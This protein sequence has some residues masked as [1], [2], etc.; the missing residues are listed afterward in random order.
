MSKIFIKILVFVVLLFLVNII[1]ILNFERR[2]PNFKFL[3][4]I[5]RNMID[6]DESIELLRE[7]LWEY[8]RCYRAGEPLISDLEFDRLLRRLEE[9]EKAAGE[10]VPLDSP[11]RRVGND[12]VSE[13]ATLPHR[14]PMLSI[15]NTYNLGELREFGNRVERQLKSETIDSN[16]I[17]AN[18]VD[19]N[20][21]DSNKVDSNK[22]ASSNRDVF[23]G[24]VDMSW[25][26]ELK[27]DGVAAALI[28]ED[29][30][31]VR[32]LTRGNGISGDDITHNIRTIKDIPLKLRTPAGEKPPKLLEVRGEI[33]MRNS[34]LTILNQTQ[35]ESG[36]AAYAN[37]RNVTAGSIR[38]L[39]SRICAGRRLRFFAHSIGE[40][41]GLDV[42]NH[43]DFLKA[44]EKF[45]INAT[46]NAK[47]FNSFEQ[48]AD[49]CE[50]LYNGD[51]NFL[52]TLDFEIDG[53]VLKA[54]DFSLR[55]RLGATSKYPRWVI[56]YKVEKYEA[57]TRLERISVQVGKTGVITPV[58]ELTPVEL[59][60]TTVARASLHNAEEIER[61][62]IRAGDIVV[63]EKAG[64]IIPHVVRVEKHLR[65]FE[66]GEFKFPKNC[67]SCNS[68]LVKDDG[69][70]YIRCANPECPA[71]IKERIRYFASRA[72]MDIEGLG[73]K[74]INQLVDNKL[75]SNFGDIYRLSEE[76][77]ET[78][79]IERMGKRLAEKLINNIEKSKNRDLARFLN[80][81]SIRHVG[82]GTAKLIAK[83]FGTLEKLR[84]AT[85]LEISE[86]DGVG[87]IIAASLYQFL[88]SDYGKKTIDDLIAEFSKN[89]DG[90]KQK[91]FFENE[92]SQN[93]LQSGKTNILT[94]SENLNVTKIQNQNQNLKT[95]TNEIMSNEKNKKPLAGLTI[96][97][98]GT[99]ENF[100]RD[101]I[102][103][104]VE[105][106]GGKATSSV[107][108]NTS[109]VLAG[110]KPG[111]T[112]LKQAENL[113]IKIIDETEFNKLIAEEKK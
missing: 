28:Y 38:L 105:F 112:K 82:V 14:I 73:D 52:S 64:K 37:T 33:Y 100:K 18:K 43:Y 107:S 21:V 86:I 102:N 15:E 74:L 49:Y 1:A 91:S 68:E 60:G 54:N 17:D 110:K 103:S 8:D 63:V 3:T 93:L 25:V 104:I 97:V 46:P 35:K 87:E 113:G 39:D 16:K 109:F 96:V 62:D 67:P 101:E 5:K 47:V 55:K 56:A 12:T 22:V 71:Q 66:N 11:T 78:G 65:D 34:D 57:V 84:N 7:R 98:T 27:V 20:K 19:S 10:P 88:H 94:E 70:V 89:R 80:A 32:G 61:K 50:S 6:K 24:G 45:G 26:V 31:L 106:Y 59:A 44:V 95:G 90:K 30:F 51:D 99:L 48:A 2:I 36:Q 111:N 40:C 92:Y 85:Q 79:G 53:L 29:G 41:E 77:L 13:L 108:S 4:S 75:I 23:V 42:K 76:K 58:A 81:L 69:G 83:H 72:A 9:L